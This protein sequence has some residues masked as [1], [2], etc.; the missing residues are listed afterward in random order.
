MTRRV[1]SIL[2]IMSVREVVKILRETS[3]NGFPVLRYTSSELTSQP[4]GQ[5]VGLILRHQ[6]MLLLEERALIEVDSIALTRPLSYR[7]ANVRETRIT[8]E[9][10]YLEHAMQVYHHNHHPHR[11]YLNSEPEAVDKLEI[12]GLLQVI[13]LMEKNFS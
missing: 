13:N 10:N 6:I 5:L 7:F 8:R 1:L 12:D 4:D 3:H 11:R 2:Q 9:Q